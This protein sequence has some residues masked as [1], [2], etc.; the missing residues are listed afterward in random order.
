MLL[1]DIEAIRRRL[2]VVVHEPGIEF[3]LFA[4]IAFSFAVARM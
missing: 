4:D 1:G 2:R 3:R